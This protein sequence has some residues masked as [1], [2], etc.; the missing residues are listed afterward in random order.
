MVIS[1]A[2][3]QTSAT[4]PAIASQRSAANVSRLRSSRRARPPYDHHANASVPGTS[5]RATTHSGGA[6]RKR[7]DCS[8]KVA[9]SPVAGS[10]GSMIGGV[11]MAQF[12][13]PAI[14]RASAAS[15]STSAR[16]ASSRLGPK[17]LRSS[18][19]V[20]S[21]SAGSPVAIASMPS[22]VR[23]SSWPT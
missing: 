14:Q 2:G 1:N 15:A 3:W 8:T 19:A 10:C 20:V 17:S 7:N 12:L 22:A 13:L 18:S 11:A 23:A 9:A 5:S 21:A 4:Q 16:V 6:A